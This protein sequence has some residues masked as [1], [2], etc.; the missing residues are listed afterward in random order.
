[1]AE[2]TLDFIAQQQARILADLRDI[3]FAAE[4]DRK[5]LTHAYEVMVHQL[6]TTLGLF[7]A[8]IEQWIGDTNR[9]LDALTGQ[10][11]QMRAETAARFDRL[12]QLTANAD[13]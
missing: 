9:R 13:R 11:D 7:E 2:P 5:N 4:I 12:E 3:K 6:G 10:F 8:K 1:M